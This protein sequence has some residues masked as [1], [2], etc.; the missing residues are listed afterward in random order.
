MSVEAWV[1]ARANGVPDALGARVGAALRVQ[2]SALSVRRS[3]DAHIAE[4][5]LDAAVVTLGDALSAP[6]MTRAH[7]LDVLAADALATYAFEAAAE[8]GDL[9][10][11]ADRAL[12]R[13]AELGSGA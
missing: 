2:R 12:R 8:S 6:Q 4:A 5:L 13:I 10:E 7:A 9:P 3:G 1:A 11:C